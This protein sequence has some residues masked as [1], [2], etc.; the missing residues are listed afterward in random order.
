MVTYCA[1]TGSVFSC[2]IKYY[3]AAFSQFDNNFIRP[4]MNLKGVKKIPEQ[5]IT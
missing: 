4:P 5:N 3:T 2:K 1:S